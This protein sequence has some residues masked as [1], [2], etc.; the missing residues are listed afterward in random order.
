MHKLWLLILVASL[1]SVQVA[2]GPV[3]KCKD[4]KGNTT[5]SDRPC[6]EKQQEVIREEQPE[7]KQPSG[8]QPQKNRG[9]YGNFIDRAR[10]VK[11]PA[12]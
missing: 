8:Q 1:V 5:F 9:G 3:F 12:P 6:S 10:E 2:A 7:P 11:S 4:E